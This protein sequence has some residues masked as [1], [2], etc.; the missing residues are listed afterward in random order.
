MF[1]NVLGVVTR[2]KLMQ[3]YINNENRNF[4]LINDIKD[5]S[6]KPAFLNVTTVGKVYHM[7]N[8]SNEIILLH[9]KGLN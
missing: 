7:L 4:K 8:N 1:R 9:S 3:S 2:K 5:V 6:F